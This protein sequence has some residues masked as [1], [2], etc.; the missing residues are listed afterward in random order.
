MRRIRE[1]TSGFD[2]DILE[3]GSRRESTRLEGAKKNTDYFRSR[4]ITTLLL[5]IDVCR[6]WENGRLVRLV[7][8]LREIATEF[9]ML[10]LVFANG[11][12]CCSM[13]RLAMNF[14]GL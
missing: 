5:T 8:C 10:L 7:E 12:M 6:E 11:N 14:G 4:N 3:E 2:F 13:T 9:K 1:R